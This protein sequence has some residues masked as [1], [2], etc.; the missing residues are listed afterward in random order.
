MYGH[1]GTK[2]TEDVYINIPE[3]TV[4]ECEKEMT[5][6]MADILPQT[7]LILDIHIPEKDLLE[8]LPPKVYNMMG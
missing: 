8:L 5:A 1:N 4:Y 3:E 2:V 7:S 6:F